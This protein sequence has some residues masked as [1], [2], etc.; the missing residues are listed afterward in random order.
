[1][2]I[3]DRKSFQMQIFFNILPRISL[4]CKLVPVQYWEYEYGLLRHP[5]HALD[6]KTKDLIGHLWVSL[7]N[8]NA[9]F[10]SSF[11][12]E[13]TL[14]CAVLAKNCTALNQLEWRNFFRYIIR[15]KKKVALKMCQTINQCS[16]Q[17][18]LWLQFRRVWQKRKYID[19]GRNMETEFERD[20]FL[21]GL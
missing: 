5:G 17:I 20:S 7:I 9:W 4:H 15:L 1:M 6:L 13:L 18:I 21:E 8:Q 12:T 2:C 10:V 14:F 11:C 16:T 19:T 3:R